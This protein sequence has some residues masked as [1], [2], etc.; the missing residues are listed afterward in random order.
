MMLADVRRGQAASQDVLRRVLMEYALVM[1]AHEIWEISLITA[2][3]IEQMSDDLW[4]FDAGK[5]EVAVDVDACSGSLPE[6]LVRADGTL[7]YGQLAYPEVITFFEFAKR[8]FGSVPTKMYGGGVWV[9]I[10]DGGM[11][12]WQY[13]RDE[14]IDHFVDLV[15]NSGKLFDKGNLLSRSW[16]DRDDWLMLEYKRDAVSAQDL[17]DGFRRGR[18]G[19]PGPLKGHQ[20]LLERMDDIL[21]RERGLPEELMVRLRSIAGVRSMEMD[22]R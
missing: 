11:R 2:E 3:S 7:L 17:I 16:L 12:L 6:G 1:V 18:L 15:H 21:R 20:E 8:V 5:N 9:N 19:V 10:V 22:G 13:G 14:D 4:P